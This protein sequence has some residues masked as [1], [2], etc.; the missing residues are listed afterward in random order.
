MPPW[1]VGTEAQVRDVVTAHP[2]DERSLKRCEEDVKRSGQC[3]TW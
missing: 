2:E 1:D 3:E